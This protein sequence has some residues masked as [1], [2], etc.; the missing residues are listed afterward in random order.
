MG[1]SDVKNLFF[2][3]Q[4]IKAFWG[5]LPFTSRHA[6]TIVQKMFGSMSKKV[7]IL[8]RLKIAIGV[9]TETTE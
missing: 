8:T 2:L 6:F 1:L 5:F 7:L 9:C 4:I 3:L